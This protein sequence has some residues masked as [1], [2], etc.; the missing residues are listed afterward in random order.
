[1]RLFK[2]TDSRKEI[3]EDAEC[4]IFIALVLG[5]LIGFSFGLAVN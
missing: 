5:L 1:M 3:I 4:Y 2:R